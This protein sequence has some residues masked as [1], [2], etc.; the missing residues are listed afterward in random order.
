MDRLFRGHVPTQSKTEFQIDVVQERD[1][2]QLHSFLFNVWI[3]T[4]KTIIPENELHKIFKE[5]KKSGLILS[6]INSVETIFLKATFFNRI[7]GV[8]TLVFFNELEAYLCRFY[9]EPAFQSRGIGT[10]LFR[11]N[12]SHIKTQKILTLEVEKENN[13]AVKFYEKHLFNVFDCKKSFIGNFPIEIYKMKR[14]IY[15]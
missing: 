2:E 7:I 4:Y 14:E 3:S 13:V 1:L 12:L 11:E 15:S 10:R 6:Q 5:W 8:S 9:I